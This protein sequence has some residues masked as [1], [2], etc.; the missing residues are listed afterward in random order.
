[1]GICSIGCKTKQGAKT[2]LE[3]YGLVPFSSYQL[4]KFIIKKDKNQRNYCSRLNYYSSYWILCIEII[5]SLSLFVNAANH[6]IGRLTNTYLDYVWYW[7]L[8]FFYLK[9]SLKFNIKQA[10]NLEEQNLI[11]NWILYT[12][13]SHLLDLW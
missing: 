11:R 13:T 12:E 7:I 6:V 5:K 2:S 1:L 4:N 9:N 10:I 3:I 8:I